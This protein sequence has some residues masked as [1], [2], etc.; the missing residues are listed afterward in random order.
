MILYTLFMTQNS[1]FVNQINQKL[2]FSQNLSRQLKNL[3]INTWRTWSGVSSSWKKIKQNVEPRDVFSCCCCCSWIFWCM[4][5]FNQYVNCFFLWN[6][7]VFHQF[8]NAEN[9]WSSKK[10]CRFEFDFTKRN[11]HCC[12]CWLIVWPGW[13]ILGRF[14]S[15]DASHCTAGCSWWMLVWLS[16]GQLSKRSSRGSS[17]PQDEARFSALWDSGMFSWACDGV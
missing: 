16:D 6:Q 4:I 13:F 5:W 12:F 11:F 17:S 1:L 14:V 3:N 7:D 2:F 8:V 9:A 15:A 10:S